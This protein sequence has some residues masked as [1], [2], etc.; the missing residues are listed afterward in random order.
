MQFNELNRRLELSEL[1]QH[2]R[3]LISHRFEVQ[4]EFSNAIDQTVRLMDQ[5]VTRMQEVMTIN[6]E[7]MRALTELKRRQQMDGVEVH[8][9]RIDPDE[10]D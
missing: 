4:V 2:A 8:S 9:V 10:K 7:T 5:L 6:T 1:D 3:Y